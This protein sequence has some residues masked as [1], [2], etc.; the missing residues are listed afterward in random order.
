MLTASHQ[1]SAVTRRHEAYRVLS[2]IHLG[3]N[4]CMQT[5]TRMAYTYIDQT[6]SRLIVSRWPDPLVVGDE[7]VRNGEARRLNSPRLPDSSLASP[8]STSFFHATLCS[9]SPQAHT[10]RRIAARSTLFTTRT[11]CRSGN[12][13]TQASRASVT[14]RDMPAMRYTT[15]LSP[16]GPRDLLRMSGNTVSSVSTPACRLRDLRSD[17]L[18]VS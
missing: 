15:Y 16:P 12:L 1:G 13:Q 17:A 8:A 14:G 7:P 4:S 3:D 5:S 18:D 6:I 11:G 10:S 9:N 2:R